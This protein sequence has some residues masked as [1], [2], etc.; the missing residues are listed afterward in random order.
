M[1]ERRVWVGFDV[2]AD[3]LAACAKCNAGLPI[4]E[5]VLPATIEGVTSFLEGFDR[6][7]HV[8]IGLEAGSTGI[9]LTRKLRERGYTV[10]VF[11]TRQASKFLAIRANKTDTNDA[12]GL[13]DLVR[14]GRGVVSEVMVKGIECQLLRSKLMLRQ[15]LIQHRMAG[16]GAIRSAFRLN[17]GK[18]D[19][20]YSATSLRRNVLAEIN[21]IREREGFD[22]SD[23]IVPV[24]DICEATRRHLEKIDRALMHMAKNHPIC[25]RF[26]TI[27]GVGPITALSFYSS[28]EDPARFKRNSDVGAYLGLVPRLK[29]SGTSS[30]RWGISKMGNSMTRTHLVS[31][32]AAMMRQKGEVGPLRAWAD[33]LRERSNY[34]RVTTA[35]A[36]KLAVVMMS[37]WKSGQS[38][39][40]STNIIGEP[41]SEA[42]E[43]ITKLAA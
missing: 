26:L 20:C 19:K 34:R 30:V 16:E 4:A 6:P 25:S 40:F 2:G 23:D 43:P 42:E 13:S 7:E 8:T 24:L 39:K 33:N 11:D 5:A 9:H 21:N 29:Q 12:S 35:L 14:L 41:K 31:A 27:P 10:H 17:G 1:V 36:R 32:A 28:V 18:L 3:E 15:K 37:M 22:L 38:F